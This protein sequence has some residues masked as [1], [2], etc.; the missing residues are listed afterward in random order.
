MKRL[1]NRAN[2]RIDEVLSG[3]EEGRSATYGGGGL[4]VLVLVIVILVILVR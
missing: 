2:E 3:G 1:L 4:L